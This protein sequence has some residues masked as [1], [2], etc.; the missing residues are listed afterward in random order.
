MGFLKVL[1]R[2]QTY[3]EY[4]DKEKIERYKMH[5]LRQFLALYEG[6]KDKFIAMKDLKWG[7]EMEYQLYQTAPPQGYPYLCNAPHL[8]L[9]NRGPE[10][11]TAWNESDLPNEHDIMLMPEFGGWMVEA[12]PRA[13]YNSI[14]DAHELLS[15]D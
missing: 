10:L 12:V 7:E 3:N 11:I 5:G 13:P 9:S 8:Q 6:N 14:V 4:K 2:V 1:G 15:C